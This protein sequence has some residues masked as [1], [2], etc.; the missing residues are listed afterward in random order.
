MLELKYNEEQ[1]HVTPLSLQRDGFFHFRGMIAV[2]RV[3]DFAF[4]SRM[5]STVWK[6][7]STALGAIAQ[8]VSD[9]KLFNA[10]LLDT[11]LSVQRDYTML[12]GSKEQILQMHNDEARFLPQNQTHEFH[13]KYALLTHLMRNQEEVN[14]T[15]ITDLFE[16]LDKGVPHVTS[17]WFKVWLED[18][19]S[20]W[21]SPF[22]CVPNGAIGEKFCARVNEAS[23]RTDILKDDFGLHALGFIDPDPKLLSPKALAEEKKFVQQILQITSPK[24]TRSEDTD[25]LI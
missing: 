12:F 22:F 16:L 18:T 13:E 6:S 11:D 3:G 20:D 8:F 2:P 25:D 1:K 19:E 10:S 7:R 15:Q 4:R 14:N 23:K 17:S 5:F 9:G 21:K 24:P